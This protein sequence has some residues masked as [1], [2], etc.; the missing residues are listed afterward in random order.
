MN[1]VY[2]K[3]RY[4]KQVAHKKCRG[5]GGD[6]PKGRISWCSRE[7]YKK[8]CPQMVLIAVRKRDNHIC[9]ICHKSI[10]ELQHQHSLIKPENVSVFYKEYSEW[11]KQFPREEYDHIVPFSEGGLTILENM[12]TLCSWCHKKRTRLWIK[13]RVSRE[14][15]Q[16]VLQFA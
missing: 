8:Y 7:C 3:S 5:C 6:V 13:A 10:K 11:M 15:G 9:H 12:R 16:E 14:R 1:I 4:P 2:G